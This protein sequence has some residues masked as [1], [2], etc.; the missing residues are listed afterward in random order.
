MNDIIAPPLIK[1]LRGQVLYRE[2]LAKYTSWRTGGPADILFLPTDLDDI[3]QFLRQIP[4]TM[5]I[6]WL[7]L[8]SNTLVRDGGVE[9]VVIIAGWT[10]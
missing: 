10:Q 8:G 5:P 1:G 7:G 3:T 2:R 4:I 9:G 6:T